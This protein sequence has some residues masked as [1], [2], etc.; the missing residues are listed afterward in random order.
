MAYKNKNAL[1]STKWLAENLTKAN[2]KIIDASWYMPAEQRNPSAEFVDAHLPGAQFF[3]IDGIA[4]KNSDLPHML[5][6]AAEFARDVGKLGISN[7]DHVICYDGGYMASAS[8]AWWTFRAFGHNSVSV[9]DG[10]SKKWLQEKR[11]MESGA[12]Q[13]MSAHFNAELQ[14]GLVRDIDDVLSLV[15]TAKGQEQIIDARSSGRFHGSDA[16]PRAGLRGGHMPGALNVPTP[17]V[18]NE[19]GTM[20]AERD[21][22]GVFAATGFAYDRPVVTTCGSGITASLLALALF[23]IGHEDVAVYDGSWT[24]WG[25]RTDTPIV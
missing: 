5:P 9:L 10:G 1:V 19:N 4:D 12:A 24:E 18:L 7:Q 21:L 23:L 25:G 8:R 2:V 13:P 15:T 3:D 22:Q 20:K 6:T 11:D 14:P 16:E 17:M